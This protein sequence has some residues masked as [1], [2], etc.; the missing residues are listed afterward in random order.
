ME[1]SIK[2]EE[3]FLPRFLARGFSDQV[4]VPIGLHN[5]V[6]HTVIERIAGKYGDNFGQLAFN[7]VEP[8]IALTV[9]SKASL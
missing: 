3:G 6:S 2:L 7:G 8:D 4:D 1:Y 9:Y 5:T